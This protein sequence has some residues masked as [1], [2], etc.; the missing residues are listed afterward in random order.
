VK[1]LLALL[2]VATLAFCGKRGDPRPPVPVVPQATT[3]LV[4]AQRAGQ[5]ILSWS[6]PS[7]TTAGRSLTD[8]RRIL[9]YRYVEE[10]PVSAAGRD[11]NAILP[12]D[13]DT[14]QPLSVALFA[15]V[16]T[17]PQAQFAKLSTRVDSIEKANLATATAGAK[18]IYADAPPFQSRDGRAVRLTY[19]V[20][21]EGEDAKGELS[22]MAIL[23][24][25]PVA[26][27]P[28][29]L[30][31]TAKAEGVTLTWDVPT[32]SVT[33]DPPVI[34]GYNVYRTAPGERVDEFA[35]PINTAPVTATIYTDTPPYGE[36]EYRVA[37]VGATG[38]PLL[39][40]DLSMPAKATYKDLIAPPAPAQITPLVETGAV[41]LIWDAVD[42]PD[43]AGYRLYRSES[44]GH[45][46][47]IREIGNFPLIPAPIAA[48]DY[49]DKKPDPGL[50][51]RYAV[52]AV[53]KNGNE[54]P[55]AW[56]AWV[57]VPKTP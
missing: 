35:S 13:I 28:K 44:T 8:V 15:K 33:Q 34:S 14:T 20:V 30:T 54:S 52:T 10:L 24:P 51:Y 53:D 49:I 39:Q 47:Q 50:A 18:L 45:G 12:G 17:I 55:R 48:T 22:N 16:P 31:A 19:A 9:I 21:T 37:A 57:V 29:A 56:T 36:H 2:V 26:A 25:L 11:P 7:L 43:L 4:V 46:D 23:V 38:P 5:V 32:T 1:K 6:Y 3:D 42:A 40:S 41:R 27:P